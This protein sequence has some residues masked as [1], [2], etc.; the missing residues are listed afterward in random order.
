MSAKASVESRSVDQIREEHRDAAEAIAA[1]PNVVFVT[2]GE[3]RTKGHR[4]GRQALIAYVRQ[5]LDVSKADQVPKR[6]TIRKAGSRRASLPTDVVPLLGEP[7]LLSGV[8]AGDL[9][10]SG[11]QQRWGTSCLSFT[12]NGNG[13]VATNAHV[14]ANMAAHTI[15]AA[16][17]GIQDPATHQLYSTGPVQ[18][19]SPFPL[20]QPTDEDFAVV[21]TGN[22]PVDYL[23]V[24]NLP[25]RITGFGR[26]A[27]NLNA[28]Y[29]YDSNGLVFPCANPEPH[30]APPTP[31]VID[32]A[33]F[34]YQNFWSLTVT[35]GSPE[36][37]HSGS[38]V[39]RGGGQNIEACGILFGGA[40]PNYAYV[41]ELEPIF[42]KVLATLP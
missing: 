10:L 12:K 33:T 26:F 13:Y 42:N 20:G 40:G 15:P 4:T 7:R 30:L 34:L 31:M 29:W 1:R 17:P 19:C 3:K 27:D 9:I 38:I 16:N 37:G 22:L 6:Q 18:Y 21:S 11:D 23:A 2:L 14:L 28:P 25:D 5:K 41:F 8:Q 39:C 24:Q 35:Q 36:H 32:G